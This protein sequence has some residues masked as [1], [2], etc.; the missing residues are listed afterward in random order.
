MEA[1]R[2]S[3]SNKTGLGIPFLSGHVMNT[4]GC[5]LNAWV[6]VSRFSY[7]VSRN[8]RWLGFRRVHLQH[9]LSL[10]MA[11]TPLKPENET[12]RHLRLGSLTGDSDTSCMSSSQAGYDTNPRGGL[13]S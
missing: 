11:L 6:A 10:L 2:H 8:E 9:S 12:A 1:S 5:P 4:E 13:G 3:Y 7:E